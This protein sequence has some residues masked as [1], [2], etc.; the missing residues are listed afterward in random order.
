[1]TQ[2]KCLHAVLVI[3]DEPLVL[4][5]ATS[6]I[7]GFGYK[8]LCKASCALDARALL[9]AQPFAMVISDVSLPDGDG[10]QILREAL[11]MNPATAGVLITGFAGSDL[12]IPP[13]LYGKIQFLEKPFTAD[14]IGHLL[15]ETF[16]RS[17]PKEKAETACA[18]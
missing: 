3:D 7:S 6:V 15:A 18:K 4:K 10:R 13:D 5:Y 16:E 2:D 17:A 11:A 9:L 8:N 1:M 14:A 12:S